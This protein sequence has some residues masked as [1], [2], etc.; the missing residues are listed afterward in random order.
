MIAVLVEHMELSYDRVEGRVDGLLF[1]RIFEQGPWCL[2]VSR[3][4]S[5]VSNGLQLGRVEKVY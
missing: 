2:V 1:S 3:G 4:V 5:D